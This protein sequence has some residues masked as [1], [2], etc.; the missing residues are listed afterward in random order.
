MER[1]WHPGGFCMFREYAGKTAPNCL[2]SEAGG[3][4]CLQLYQDFRSVC[5]PQSDD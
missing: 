2:A 3:L 4:S 5:R 1:S